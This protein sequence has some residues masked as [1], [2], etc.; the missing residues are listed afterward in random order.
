MTRA[1]TRIFGAV[2]AVF[3]ESF[4]RHYGEE[5]REVFAQRIAHLSA[6]AA[7]GA[8]LGEI[9][10]VFYSATRVRRPRIPRMQPAMLGVVGT[11]VI[12]AAFTVRSLSMGATREVM[13]LGQASL[14]VGARASLDFLPATLR[15]TYG[16]QTPAGFAIFLRVRPRLAR[17]R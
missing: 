4:R 12:A 10:D 14:G 6:P 15:L 17:M 13:S 9:V 3:P 16:T 8:T 1:L 5:M 7:I 11:F 2:L